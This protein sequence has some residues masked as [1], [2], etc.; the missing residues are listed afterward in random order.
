LLERS[1]SV[2]KKKALVERQAILIKLVERMGARQELL[3]QLMSLEMGKPILQSQ[4]EVKKCIQSIEIL[5]QKE[6]N[7]LQ[8]QEMKSSYKKS[9]IVRQPLG[10][11]YAIMPWNFPLWQVI[12]MVIPALIAGNVI[13]LKHSEVTPQMGFEIEKMFEGLFEHPILLHDLIEHKHTE[14]VLSH[15]AVGG[16]SLTGSTQAGLTVAGIATKYLKKYVLE[17]GGS[18]PYVVCADADLKLAA[19]MIVKSRMQNTGQSCIAAK[20]CLFDRKIKEEFLDL[21]KKE[22]S[23]YQFGPPLQT[24]TTL[25]PLA[26]P[27]FKVAVQKQLNDFKAATQA[28]VVAVQ[29]QSEPDKS[30]YVDAHIFL[31]AKN[32]VW[33]KNQEFFSPNLIMMPF[34][35]E[36]EALQIANATDFALGAGVFSQDIERAEALASGLHAGQVSIN[37]F[38]KSEASLPFGGMKLSGIGRELGQQGF[39]EFTQIKVVSRS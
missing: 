8:P 26:H 20:R 36:S 10:V 13:Y 4:A 12:R 30:A 37:D 23:T 3:A 19:R 5:C 7:F 1:Y 21:V 25:G 39:H 27:R 35:T 29:K 11:V 33:L 15:T 6:V 32:S 14:K 2:W 31:I 22:F 17:L 9:L 16:V 28:E 24:E 34:D 18:D 38:V